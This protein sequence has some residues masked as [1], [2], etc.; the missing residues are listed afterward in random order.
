MGRRKTAALAPEGTPGRALVTGANGFLGQAVV[1][2]LLSKGWQVR[3][4]VRRPAPAL[5][6]VGVDVRLGALSDRAALAE[7]CS[8]VDCVFH[9][10]A[11]AGVWGPW[12]DYY[13]SNVV[14]TANVIEACQLRSVPKLVYTSSPSVVFGGHDAFGENES[15]P[16]PE[17]FLN[18]YSETKAA[19]ERQVLA[20]H[21]RSG[22]ATVA[23]R[24]H[25]VW[26][27]GDPHL[28]PRLLEAA[29]RGRLKRVGHGSNQVSITFIDN[30]AWAH[31][32]AA[33]NPGGK[34]YFIA[35]EQPVRLWDFIDRL[36]VAMGY[37]PVRGQ[38][39][40][41]TARTIG[42]VLESVYRTFRLSGEPPLT[43]FSA[44]QLGMSHYFN[45]DAARNDLGY[46]PIVDHESAF[47]RT[48]EA[49]KG[50]P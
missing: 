24:P 41:T 28:F 7:A 19:A 10:A 9:C 16:Y 25:L 37:P 40:V 33:E 21:G 43:R 47:A 8:D 35:D 14:G 5:K 49:L 3:A 11:K 46:A 23:L 2:L 36:L 15:Q 13:E 34:A 26:G 6:E 38:L 1:R 18:F 12:H 22:L 45:I 42:S 32:L 48:L 44:C 31:W 27:P 50:V 39:S 29:R 20:A 17:T 30:A 4:L